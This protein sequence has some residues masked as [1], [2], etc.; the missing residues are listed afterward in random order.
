MTGKSERS[1]PTLFDHAKRRRAES[2]PTGNSSE[3]FSDG[4]SKRETRRGSENL[5]AI[6]KLPTEHSE[7]LSD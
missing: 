5:R 7:Y 2:V 1:D 6:E 4:G 3:F